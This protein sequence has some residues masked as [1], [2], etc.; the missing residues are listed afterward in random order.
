MSERHR[1]EAFCRIVLVSALH[2]KSRPARIFRVPRVGTS[3]ADG[4][5]RLFRNP[6]FTLIRGT[7]NLGTRQS[8]LKTASE[9]GSGH[10]LQGAVNLT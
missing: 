7:I 8:L 4:L 10:T 5:R 2:A 9:L 3:G 1:P 6:A